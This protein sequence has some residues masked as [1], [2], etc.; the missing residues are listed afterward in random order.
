MTNL[1]S[2]ENVRDNELRK[3]QP[4]SSG[5]TAVNVIGEQLGDI[6]DAINSSTV[7]TKQNPS[8]YNVSAVNANTEY[9]Q[10]LSSNVNSFIIKTRQYV[11]LKVAFVSG[12]SGTNYVR[13]PKGASYEESGLNATGLVLYFQTSEPN[14]DIEIVEW[15]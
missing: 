10:A 3:F 14:I 1:Y 11:D 5:N 12:Q 13:I 8:I 2:S 7:V 15:V 6:V 9:S 4:D